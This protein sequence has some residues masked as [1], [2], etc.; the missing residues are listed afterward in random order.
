MAVE[1]ERHRV[2]RGRSII[3]TIADVPKTRLRTSHPGYAD[4]LFWFHFSNGSL[5]PLMGRNMM[6]QRLAVPDDHPFKVAQLG[7][8][9][10]ALDHFY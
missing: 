9:K 10:R 3:T 8:L 1:V 6:F 5:Q 2:G 7:R 4:Y